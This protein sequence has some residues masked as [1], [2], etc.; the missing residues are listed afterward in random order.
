MDYEECILI[1]IQRKSSSSSSPQV[2]PSPTSSQEGASWWKC[3]LKRFNRDISG[4]PVDDD[5]ANTRRRAIPARSLP[6]LFTILGPMPMPLCRFCLKPEAIQDE[7]Y[8]EIPESNKLGVAKVD[9]IWVL[10]WTH[11]GIQGSPQVHR[12]TKSSRNSSII[13][14]NNVAHELFDPLG[15]VLLRK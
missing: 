8:H 9:E 1:C 13:V 5:L 2:L 3:S 10:V 12:K 11:Q 14:F 4:L 6:N 7:I 15:E